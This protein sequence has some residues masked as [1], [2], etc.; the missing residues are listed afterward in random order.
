[1]SHSVCSCL[2]PQPH[3]P[4]PQVYPDL[5][6]PGTDKGRSLFPS[7]RVQLPWTQPIQTHTN[8]HVQ[9]VTISGVTLCPG[10]PGDPS[11]PP[12]VLV[13]L[14][15]SPRA[16]FGEISRLEY[17]MNPLSGQCRG[18]SGSCGQVQGL[19]PNLKEADTSPWMQSKFASISAPSGEQAWGYL[20]CDLGTSA[21]TECPTALG[22]S[23]LKMQSLCHLTEEVEAKAESATGPAAPRESVAE[24]PPISADLALWSYD[25]SCSLG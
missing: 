20:L 24:S 3:G 6:G 15:H 17:E 18:L 22:S 23:S 2:T 9:V 5:V 16:E 21:V 4:L 8:K 19:I 7:M 25:S 14:N 11:T 13:K 1:M 12:K 10:D